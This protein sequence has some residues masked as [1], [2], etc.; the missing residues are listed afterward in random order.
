MPKFGKAVE[1]GDVLDRMFRAMEE[2][3]DMMDVL[4]ESL[5][6][7]DARDLFDE[8]KTHFAAAAEVAEDLAVMLEKD[9][10]EK[11]EE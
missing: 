10:L 2:V 1:P 5:E 11:E 6:G 8:F 4:A 9:E 3:Q 7:E